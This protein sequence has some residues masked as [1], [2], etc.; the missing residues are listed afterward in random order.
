MD[1]NCQNRPHINYSY[2]SIQLVNAKQFPTRGIIYNVTVFFPLFPSLKD[3]ILLPWCFHR[4]SVSILTTCVRVCAIVSRVFHYRPPQGRNPLLVSCCGHLCHF[5]FFLGRGKKNNNNNQ[6][7]GCSPLL[8]CLNCIWVLFWCPARRLL[9]KLP[10][11]S[12]SV[13]RDDVFWATRK[14][15]ND[16]GQSMVTLHI[17]ASV[18]T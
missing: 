12:W 18:W 2:I 17:K 13:E 6:I 9:Q 1:W 14:A 4:C 15:A 11:R 5:F 7:R 16:W 3:K 10:P 8:L